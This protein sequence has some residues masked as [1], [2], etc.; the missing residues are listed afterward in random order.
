MPAAATLAP[1]GDTLCSDPT[2]N[3]FVISQ[4]SGYLYD[5]NTFM[6][7]VASGDL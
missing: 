3:E 2:N 1:L 5:A 7:E 4:L 6:S